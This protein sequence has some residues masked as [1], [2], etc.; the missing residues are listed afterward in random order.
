[1]EKQ[2][3]FIIDKKPFEYTLS[4]IAGK[5]KM[6]IIYL[7]INCEVARY[8]EIKRSIT[9]ITHKMLSSQL[10]ELELDGII[11]RK[12]YPQIPP[13]VE[14]SLTAKGQSLEQLIKDICNWG[15]NNQV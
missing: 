15:V 8:G 7:L 11:N 5:W 1:M 3:V 6:K 2:S 14:Y 12:E 13:K 9:G 10:K 4:I